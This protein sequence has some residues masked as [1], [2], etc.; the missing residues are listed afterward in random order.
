MGY[1]DCPEFMETLRLVEVIIKGEE[2]NE[3]RKWT[4]EPG[5]KSLA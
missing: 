5:S 2:L 3:Q 1:M 4:Q